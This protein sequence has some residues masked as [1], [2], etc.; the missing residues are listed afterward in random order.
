MFSTKSKN[1]KESRRYDIQEVSN[2]RKKQN[3]FPRRIVSENFKEAAMQ[4]TW[5]VP[6][7]DCR[8]RINGNRGRSSK[9]KMKRSDVYEYIQKTSPYW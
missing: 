2:G 3:K 6:S 7:S 8:W 5:R 4:Q 9:T 1:E